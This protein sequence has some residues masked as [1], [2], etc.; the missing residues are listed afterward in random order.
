MTG[1]RLA[2]ALRAVGPAITYT[3]VN[4]LTPREALKIAAVVLRGKLHP[5]LRG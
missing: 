4:P 1:T 5:Q 3:I 2:V